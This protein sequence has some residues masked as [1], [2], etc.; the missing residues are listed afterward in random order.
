MV[1]IVGKQ[2]R[3]NGDGEENTPNSTTEGCPGLFVADEM[4][5]RPF[6]VLSISWVGCV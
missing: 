3:V 2:K 6:H 5:Q 1:G 4:F